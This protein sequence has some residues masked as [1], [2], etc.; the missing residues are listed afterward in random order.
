MER[1]LN[2]LTDELEAVKNTKTEI[3]TEIE[4]LKSK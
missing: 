4:S 3:E 2:A 1:S